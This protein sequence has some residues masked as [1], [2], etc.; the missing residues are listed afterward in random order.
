M[1]WEFR[2][3]GA[4]DPVVVRNVRRLAGYQHPRHHM[5]PAA[6]RLREVFAEPLALMDGAAVAAE[7][8]AVLPVLFHLLWWHD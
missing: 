5:E 4:A 2:L 1:G 8:L 6:S 7:P 3:L